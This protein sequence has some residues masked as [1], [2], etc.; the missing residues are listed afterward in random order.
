MTHLRCVEKFVF[1]P[2]DADPIHALL[3]KGTVC[4]AS[5]TFRTILARKRAGQDMTDL[6]F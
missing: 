3:A 6:L 4:T 2:P 1:A 5:R